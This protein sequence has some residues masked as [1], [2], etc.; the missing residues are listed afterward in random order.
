MTI[1]NRLD[2]WKECGVISPEQYAPLTGLVRREPYSLFL[3]AGCIAMGSRKPSPRVR[4]ASYAE[5]WIWPFQ[6]R[7]DA[8]RSGIPGSRSRRYRFT[9]DLAAFWTALCSFCGDGVCCVAASLLDRVPVLQHLIVAA[10]YAA[11]L[12]VVI[13]IRP[14]DRCTYLENELSIFEA[15]L[16]LGIY[17]AMSLRISPANLIEPLRGGFRTAA[18][19]PATIHWTTFALTWCLPAIALIRGVR[20]K[21]RLVMGAGAISAV[22]TLVTNKPHLGWQRHTW[23]PMALGVFLIGVALFLRR[24]L[25]HA[26]GGVRHGFTA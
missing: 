12:G 5:E 23:D 15:L 22:L 13:A 9:L 1:L 20:G 18:S 2:Q 16:W 6:R 10:T 8:A 11:E 19:F 25:A 14:R 24:W 3:E 7:K 21:D 17:L 26:P 4:S